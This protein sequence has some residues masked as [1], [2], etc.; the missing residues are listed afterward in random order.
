LSIICP[1]L[2]AAPLEVARSFDDAVTHSRGSW[3]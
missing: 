2:S 1:R 3:C